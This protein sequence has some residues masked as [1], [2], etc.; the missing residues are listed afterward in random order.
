MPRLFSIALSVAFASLAFGDP[1]RSQEGEEQPR[2]FSMVPA[3]RDFWD[4]PASTRLGSWIEGRLESVALEDRP[5]WLLMFVD[6]LKGSQLG[7]TD[8]WFSRPTNGSRFS[9]DDVRERFDLDTNGFVTPREWPGSPEDFEAVDANRDGLISSVDFDWSDHALAGGPGVALFS[10]A[11]ADGNGKVT[12]AEFLALFDRLDSGALDFL[13]RDEMKRLLE[14]GTFTR[15]MREADTRGDGPPPSPNGP[16]K[17]TLI[18][19]LFSQEIGSLQAGPGLGEPAP[20]FTLGSVEGD[21]DVTL[22]AYRERLDRPIVLV[23]G[24]FT[25]GP[26]RGQAGNIEKLYRR[27]KDRAGF[28]LVYVREAHPTDGWHMFD[29]FQKGY[30][31]PQPFDDPGRL[32]VARRCQQTLDLGLPMVVDPIDDPV[33]SAYSGM[34]ARL[35]L[36]DRDGLVAFKSGRGPFG[37]KPSELEQALALLLTLEP[38]GQ[39]AGQAT[40]DQGT[41]PAGP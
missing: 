6:I 12:R 41:V 27:Y 33:G 17:S 38:D 3:A 4:S 18:R 29:N 30:T 20:D 10:L 21:R 26:F 7:P 22:S 24:N 36:I 2:P 13:S 15:L 37:F 23:F 14:Q 39:T 34:P 40:E 19:G 9:W 25:C 5:E 28:L 16:S 32:A 31:L 8:G 35:Y 11:D 1:A